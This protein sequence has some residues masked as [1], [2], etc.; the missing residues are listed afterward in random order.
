MTPPIHVEFASVPRGLEK[1]LAQE[2]YIRTDNR[3]HAK[4]FKDFSRKDGRGPS[5]FYD[6]FTCLRGFDVAVLLKIHYDNSNNSQLNGAYDLAR[7]LL[8][9]FNVTVYYPLT[10]IE[11]TSREYRTQA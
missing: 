7:K 10:D 2:G 9:R 5:L 11:I 8:L 3:S 6:A 1:F 4:E